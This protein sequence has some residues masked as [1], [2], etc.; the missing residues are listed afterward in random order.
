MTRWLIFAA[1]CLPAGASWLAGEAT[2]LT[3]VIQLAA[4]YIPNLVYHDESLTVVMRV[5]N[6]GTAPATG[7][8]LVTAVF[9]AGGRTVV[10]SRDLDL[11]P[12][13]EAR[14]SLELPVVVFERPVRN[15]AIAA[16]TASFALR[17][18]Q[19]GDPVPAFSVDPGNACLDRDGMRLVLVVTHRVFTANRRWLFAHWAAGRLFPARACASILVMAAP[20]AEAGGPPSYLASLKAAVPSVD[21]LPLADLPAGGAAPVLVNCALVRDG[22]A[23]PARERAVLCLPYTDVLRGTGRREYRL[24]VE[25]MVQM[26][27]RAGYADIRIVAPAAPAAL[28]GRMQ[29]YLDELA[30]IAGVYAHPF[31]SAAPPAAADYWA[32]DP[33]GN[34]AGR[35]PNA[36]GQAAL[37]RSLRAVVR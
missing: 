12:G 31:I 32:V 5:T 34:M 1:L 20:L 9:P 25:W 28:A 16:G 3:P 2:A 26:L 19:P 13:A 29:G 17:L 23:R 33:D 18:I 7:P 15:L 10:A 37:D 30:D 35:F 11:A 4:E 6:R 27:E 36:R 21:I 24:A 22:L 8:L 14:L